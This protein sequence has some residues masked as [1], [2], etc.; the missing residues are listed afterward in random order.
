[1]RNFYNKRRYTLAGK[2]MIL[3]VIIGIITI[4]V[5]GTTLGW[6]F[7]GHF[8][9][10]IRP[11]L[12]LY[13]EYIQQD[14]GD[15]PTLAEAQK[16]SQRLHMDIHYLGEE[17]WSTGG[18]PLTL[19]SLH[20]RRT[21]R[22]NGVD[23]GLGH[24]DGQ[25]Y[26][27]A[28]HADYTVVF[29]IEKKRNTPYHLAVVALI[30]VLLL[31]LY[32]LIR[33]LFSPIEILR[34]GIERIGSGE[35]DYRL[36]I[37]RKDELGALANSINHMADDIQQMLDAK[38]QL[39][40]AIS[41]E[42]RTPLTRAK[43]ITEMLEKDAERDEL[44]RELNEM[45]N[46]IQELLESERLSQNHSVL[47]KSETD[48]CQLITQVIKESSTSQTLNLTCQAG[49]S[50][51]VDSA[52]IKLLLKNLIDNALQHN[53][54]EGKSPS[55]HLTCEQGNITI[56]VKDHGPGIAPEHLPHLTEPFYR[57]DPARQ[58]QTGGYG[59]GLYLCSMIAQAHGGTLEISSVLYKGTTITLTLPQADK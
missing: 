34:D 59:L 27:V 48:L 57:V 14:L 5:I 33:R 47:H 3:F 43:L 6:A 58:R 54:Q 44:N 4:V 30:I 28:R 17:N 40:L 7:R 55:V 29:A 49:I 26:L 38:R 24:S 32:F 2:Q 13:M 8:K 35:L 16:L 50:A 37:Q 53:P 12:Q 10:G 18:V 51:D 22:N 15:P 52:R 42:L 9:E 1:M 36:N 23:F 20:T 19:E 25:E 46:L 21:F 56:T 31:L 39:L 11:H 45:D 41:H